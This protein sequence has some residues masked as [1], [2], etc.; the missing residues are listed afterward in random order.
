MKYFDNTLL[1]AS[2]NIF[3]SE[4]FLSYG[5]HPSY[6]TG[7]STVRTQYTAWYKVTSYPAYAQKPCLGTKVHCLLFCTNHISG[8]NTPLFFFTAIPHSF[9]STWLYPIE[10]PSSPASSS[11]L[12]SRGLPLNWGKWCGAI[13]PQSWDFSPSLSLRLEF[14]QLKS[15]PPISLLLHPASSLRP[16]HLYHTI[17]RFSRQ[18][19]QV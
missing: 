6:A 8:W 14:S 19:V 2:T 10:T 1:G 4:N 9:P 5:V 7:V 3:D 13:T 12:S 16:P 17:Y 18:I 11:S 15:S